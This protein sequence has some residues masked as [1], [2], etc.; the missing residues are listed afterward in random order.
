MRFDTE[1][2]RNLF[3]FRVKT[4][5]YEGRVTIRNAVLINYYVALIFGLILIFTGIAGFLIPQDRA[6]TSGAPAYNVFHIFFGLL[7]LVLVSSSHETCIRVFNVGFG[8]IDLYQAVASRMSWFP[9][10]QFRWKGADD[11]LHVLIGL[12]LVIIGLLP[13]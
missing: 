8:L 3:N 9:A 5:R 2:S 13:V 11:I 12:A 1:S 6:L 7:A 10:A 4:S